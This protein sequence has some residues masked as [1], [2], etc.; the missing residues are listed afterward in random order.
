[1]HYKFEHKTGRLFPSIL[2]VAILMMGISGQANAFAIDA[3]PDWQVRWDNSPLYNLGFRAQGIKN[4]IG[5]NT[6]Y[7]E[8]DYKFSKRGDVVTDRVSDLSEFDAVYK[9]KYGFRVSASV[10]RD[11]AYDSDVENHP[12]LAQNLWGSYSNG[13]YSDYTNRYYRQ[14]GEFL[15]A[16]VFASFQLAGRDASLKVG[17]LTQFWGNTQFYGG[18]GINYGQNPSDGIKGLTS[19]G[20]KAKEL[21]IP[22]AQ[23][24]LQT[25]L[26][27]TLSMAAQVFGEFRPNR[28][29]EGGTFLGTV[30][31]GLRGADRVAVGPGVFVPR[32]EDIEPS[33]GDD[34][35]LKLTWATEWM[36]AGN[37]GF[38]Y[39]KLSETQPWLFFTPTFSD[40]HL[41]YAND[42]TMY[43]IRVDPDIGDATAG[44]RVS[45]GFE[46]SF[47]K[48]TALN[49]VGAAT[50]LDNATDGPRG[51]TLQ[52][53]ANA[54]WGMPRTS[55]WDTGT[56]IAELG[57]QRL[58]STNSRNKDMALNEHTSACP[59]GAKD[60]C[61]TKSSWGVSVYL[62][63]QWL[64]VWTGVNLDMPTFVQYQIKGNTATIAGANKEGN[65]VYSIGLHAN[66][67]S[68]YD[69]TLAYNGYHGDT[70]GRQALGPVGSYNANDYGGNGLGF[71]N[72][73]GW[74]SLTLGTSF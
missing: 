71:F 64:S 22:R 50:A 35:G 44:T 38:Y 49:S 15:D 74:V 68:R 2:S 14:G 1:M 41:V 70:N 7:S 67:R 17:R 47:R 53:L 33:P 13:R 23:I 19:P 62:D 73:R 72:D 10:W 12:G 63:P 52:F 66:I 16:F 20:S 42:V 65:A 27:D 21:T 59:G 55:F 69:V 43:G 3:G 40:Y 48:D 58:V 46:L 45:S 61:N 5:N 11:F 25:G 4:G 9:D 6:L 24:L 8:S 60:G 39:L 32:G 51:D 28:L 54:M 18:L 56:L 34:W 31:F 36:D 57:Y 29:P 37:I 26:T 30:G